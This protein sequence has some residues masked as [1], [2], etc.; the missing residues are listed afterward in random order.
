M[1]ATLFTK[2]QSIIHSHHL[3]LI[4][5]FCGP[6]NPHILLKVIKYVFLSTS[7]CF[8]VDAGCKTIHAH[9]YFIHITIIS[10]KYPA[11]TYVTVFWKT[12]HLRTRTEIHLLPVH[13]RHTHALS[14]NMHQ[15]P[16][17]RL[18][19]LL[20]RWLFTDAMKLRGGSGRVNRAAWSTKLL[21]MAVW[22]FLVDCIS[23]CHLLKAQLCFLSPNGC[24]NPPSSPRPPSSPTPLPPI[25]PP[26]I[27]SIH[28]ITGTE[29]LSQK[30]AAFK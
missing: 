10:V 3:C 28:D 16:D 25:C 7:A 20:L 2:N 29:R 8:K 11:E 30:P 4:L 26:S 15:A 12:D 24:F 19:G 27:D 6:L 1:I 23:L 18:P 13:D 17:N 22:A 5:F 14:R 9:T 21:L